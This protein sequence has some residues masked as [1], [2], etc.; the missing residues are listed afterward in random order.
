MSFIG[1]PRSGYGMKPADISLLFI[2]RKAGYGQA[3]RK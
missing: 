2:A 3:P 1:S